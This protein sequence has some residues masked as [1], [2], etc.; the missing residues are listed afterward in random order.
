MPRRR[1]I[2]G[3]VQAHDVGAGEQI[4]ERQPLDAM[5]LVE[6]GVDDRVKSNDAHL[7]S[8]RSHRDGAAMRP[9]PTRPSVIPRTGRTRAR[10]Q[11]PA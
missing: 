10:S 3:Y 8:G 9:I 5:A 2:Q 7:E 6:V 11:P 4:V 1:I